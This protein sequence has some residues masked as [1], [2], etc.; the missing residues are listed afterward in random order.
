MATSAVNSRSFPRLARR[1]DAGCSVVTV[2]WVDK[3]I[4]VIGGYWL[5][6]TSLLHPVIVDGRST[7][8]TYFAKS[9]I[10][11]TTQYSI[12]IPSTLWT[13]SLKHQL[14]CRSSIAVVAKIQILSY[15]YYYINVYYYIIPPINSM[16][17]LSVVVTRPC[18]SYKANTRF[19]TIRIQ[20]KHS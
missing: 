12:R 14:W 17:M 18:T 15:Y 6:M 5:T 20:H 4:D 19:S 7:H 13:C 11:N 9:R 1:D 2:D 8:V 16:N 3:R 10:N